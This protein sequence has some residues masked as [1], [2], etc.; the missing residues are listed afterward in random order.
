MVKCGELRGARLAGVL[1]QCSFSQARA[2]SRPS[3]APSRRAAVVVRAQKQE[4]VKQVSTAMAAAALATVVG[5]AD[6]QPAAADVAGLTPCSSSKAFAKAEK[7]ELKTLTKRLKQVRAARR[8]VPRCEMDQPSDKTHTAFS[9]A[10]IGWACWCGWI[11]S[12][13]MGGCL[14]AAGH[15]TSVNVLGSNARA[16]TCVLRTAVRGWFCSRSGSGGHH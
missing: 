8:A 2:A 14:R 13:G 16:H 5:F 10:A 4:A 11:S 9:A 3:L 12:A 6:V 15:C 1:L 7:K